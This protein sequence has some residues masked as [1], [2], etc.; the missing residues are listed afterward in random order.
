[1]R[2]INIDVDEKVTIHE[3]INRVVD[4]FN[5]YLEID[6]KQYRLSLNY[7]MYNIK[8]SKKNG[9]PKED[10]PCMI[11]FN[12]GYNKEALISYCQVRQLSIIYSNS[13]VIYM[14]PKT[15]CNCVII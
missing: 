10:L 12:I 15:K 3:L 4:T 7:S 2:F 13:E 11:N 14:K 6:C 1:V 9:M 8:P 5:K